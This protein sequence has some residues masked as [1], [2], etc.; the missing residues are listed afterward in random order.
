MTATDAQLAQAVKRTSDET[1]NRYR[2]NRNWRLYEKVWIYHNFPA[3]GRSWLDF[4]CGTGEITTQL[5]LL[6]ASKVIGLDVTTGLL[7]Q[8]RGF[9]PPARPI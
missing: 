2:A 6:G 5:A 8:T 9:T 4:G 3:S 1:I 7:E